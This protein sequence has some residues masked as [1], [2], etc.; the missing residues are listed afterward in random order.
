MTAKTAKL[1]S[2]ER[3][4]KLFECYGSNPDSWPVDEKVSALSLIQ[5]SSELKALQQEIA[6]FDKILKEGDVAIDVAETIDR[7]K[8]NQLA[9]GLPEQD[10]R[11]NPH[12]VNRNLQSRKSFFDLNRSLGAIAASVAIMVITLSIVT[13]KPENVTP[14][15]TVVTAKTDLD[16]WMWEQFVS[17]PAD[18]Y[19]EP[20]TMM[21]LLE[22]EE[23]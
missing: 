10:R 19:D 2:P 12:Y 21:A 18:D 7:E 22:L 14:V 9:A 16:G 8:V 23:I 11:P 5:H 3:V 1:I 6:K 17:E 15:S 20:L 13:L 4:K